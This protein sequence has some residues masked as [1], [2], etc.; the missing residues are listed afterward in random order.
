MTFVPVRDES[1]KIHKRRGLQHSAGRIRVGFCSNVRSCR[2]RGVRVGSGRFG[3]VFV[4]AFAYVFV[5]G[6]VFAFAFD[7]GCV[8]AYVFGFVFGFAAGRQLRF[9]VGRFTVGTDR[10]AWTTSHR[11]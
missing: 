1:L 10:G 3:C 5:F 6:C 8:F 7:F 4:F 9:F 11:P 2:I